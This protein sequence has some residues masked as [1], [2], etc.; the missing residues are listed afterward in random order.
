MSH[1]VTSFLVGVVVVKGDAFKEHCQ[2]YPEQLLT[3][4]NSEL[5]KLVLT[6]GNQLSHDI[7]VTACT[8]HE[9]KKN[10]GCTVKNFHI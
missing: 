10:S 9:V 2:S 6:M 3:T 5:P 7:K 8:I 1:M 4:L